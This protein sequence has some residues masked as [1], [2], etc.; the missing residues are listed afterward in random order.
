MTIQSNGVAYRID[1]EEQLMRFIRLAN[2]PKALMAF[3]KALEVVPTKL[4]TA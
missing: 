2:S 1:T 3:L 4:R